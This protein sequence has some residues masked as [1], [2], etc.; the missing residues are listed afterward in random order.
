MFIQKGSTRIVRCFP[1]LGI[2]IKTPIDCLGDFGVKANKAEAYLWEKTRSPLLAP[3][4]FSFFGLVVVM[5]YYPT[6]VK[7]GS[8]HNGLITSEV[9]ARLSN[10]QC[11]T[12]ITER[13]LGTKINH[14]FVDGHDAQSQNFRI[15]K[16]GRLVMT[17][18]G[19]SCLERQEKF[20]EFLGKY[21]QKLVDEYAE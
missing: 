8:G 1:S 11:F 19:I 13:I 9:L 6:A 3:V 17:D 4:L 21:G 16:E 14:L 7:K 10:E 2:V 15:N 20:E 5:R 12:S 18:Y